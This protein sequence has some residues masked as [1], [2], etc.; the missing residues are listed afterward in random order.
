VTSQ[1]WFAETAPCFAQLS[2]TT[3]LLT[4]PQPDTT[5]CTV[6][7]KVSTATTA[8]L[9]D[10]LAGARCN[11]NTFLVIDLS[12]VAFMDSDGFYTLF[13]AL[14]KHDIGGSELAVAL[15]PDTQA[16]PE[17]YVVS[18]RAAFNTYHDLAEALRAYV[19]A[20]KN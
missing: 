18:L 12:V 10:A 13:E 17:L 16:I 15:D 4:Q 9:R 11:K 1:V 8:I 3:A 2:T 5:V 6:T 20:G 7:G 19:S 14:C